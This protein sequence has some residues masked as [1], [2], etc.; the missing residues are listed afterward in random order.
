MV[1]QL[2]R[3]IFD[4]AELVEHERGF[5]FRFRTDLEIWWGFASL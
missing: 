2:I 4:K 1:N 3:S 5:R